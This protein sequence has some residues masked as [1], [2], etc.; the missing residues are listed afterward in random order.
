MKRVS[1]DIEDELDRA[2]TE[3][4]RNRGIAKAE[5]IRRTLAEAV[6]TAAARP[7]ITAIGVS[8]GP[9]DLAAEADGYL[10]G[11]GET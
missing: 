8:D 11:F 2:L 6:G 3:L 7:R 10:A 4:A 1:V 5:L 9:G